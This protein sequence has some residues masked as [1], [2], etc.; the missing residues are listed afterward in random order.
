MIISQKFER[1]SVGSCIYSDGFVNWYPEHISSS[2]DTDGCI[3]WIENR[4][5][6]SFKFSD[7]K[8]MFTFV[9]SETY[10]KSL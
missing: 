6:C 9:E 8:V 2:E 1:S 10:V 5:Q 3:E 7:D 4:V